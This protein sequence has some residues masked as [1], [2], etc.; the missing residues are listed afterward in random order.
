MM[1]FRIEKDKLGTLEIP[2]ERYY[3]IHTQRA[4]NNFRVSGIRVNPRLIKAMALV[5]AAAA[6]TNKELGYID[7]LGEYI[8]KAA[9]EIAAGNLAEEFPLDAIQGGA[10]TSTN[11]NLNEVIANRALELAGRERGDYSF[12]DPVE[13]V[14]LHQSTNDVYPTALKI[15]LIYAVRELSHTIEKIQGALQ[16]KE[17][18]FSDIITLG[19]TEMQDAVPITLG[20]Q[21][22]A[23]VEAF[24]R[25]RWRTFKCEERL[26]S[27][28]IGGT[29]VGTGLTAPRKYIFLIIDKLRRETGLGLSRSEHIMGDTANIDSL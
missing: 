3:G 2:A 7:E 4:L 29:A 8:Y 25:D 13:H 15:S 1:N 23:M 10:G 11:M 12:I 27:V 24:S 14:N 26:R 19:R 20:S 9:K 17:R 21:F 5:K 16:A 22:A 6:T 28:N 18:E